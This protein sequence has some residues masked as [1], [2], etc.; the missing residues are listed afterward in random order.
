MN[1]TLG[2]HP[3]LAETLSYCLNRGLA[4]SPA[5]LEI[6]VTD[7]EATYLEES[8]QKLTCAERMAFADG[9][10]EAMVEIATAHDI[11]RANDL[12][13]RIFDHYFYPPKP[14]PGN[15]GAQFND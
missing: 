12:L 3:A 9:E 15:H 11:E 13:N 2:S 1:I 4:L 8:L 14:Q 7:E 6:E 5:G 10:E